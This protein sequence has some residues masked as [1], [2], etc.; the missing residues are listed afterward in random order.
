MSSKLKVSVEVS[1]VA[2]LLYDALIV[3]RAV[4]LPSKLNIPQARET[5]MRAKI[6]LYQFASV[7]LAISSEQK[8]DFAFRFLEQQLA[9]V[10]PPKTALFS[11]TK[12]F[13][14]ILGA[15]K[16]VY[17]N[18]AREWLLDIGIDETDPAVLGMFTYGWVQHHLLAIET[19]N[20]VALCATS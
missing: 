18:W 17:Q 10:S 6:A 4:N 7:S 8:T 3:K 16:D 2:Q 19:L 5:T 1:Q 11:A 12:N 15:D 9:R 20:G 14:R 13:Q